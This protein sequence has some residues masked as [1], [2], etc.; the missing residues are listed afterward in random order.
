MKT[1]TLAKLRRSFVEK[2]GLLFIVNS[3]M[4]HEAPLRSLPNQ[5]A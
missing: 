1:V 3:V 5:A 2:V 4:M